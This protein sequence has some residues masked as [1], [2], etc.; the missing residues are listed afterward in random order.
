MKKSLKA[1]L[2]I[3]VVT[4]V[5]CLS[6]SICSAQAFNFETVDPLGGR[7]AV[8]G[9]APSGKYVSLTVL[10]PQKDVSGFENYTE[11]D[12]QYFGGMVAGSSSS[13][14]HGTFEHAED[15]N[16][17]FSFNIN[18]GGGDYT[19]IVN[20][21]GNKSVQTIPVYPAG[22][23]QETIIKIN[24]ATD[25]SAELVDEAIINFSL[26]N[27]PLYTDA[28]SKVT[29][30][31][32]I[33]KL[34]QQNGG[35]FAY[36]TAEDLSNMEVVL[37]DACFIAAY[38]TKNEAVITSDGS[39]LYTNSF[40]ALSGTDEL[41]DYE[42]ISD[43]GLVLKDMFTKTPYTNVG[44]ITKAFKESVRFRVLVDYDAYG[45]G[46]VA[47]Y[48]ERYGDWYEE[49]GFDFNA[50]NKYDY[51]DDVYIAVSASS[52]N[53]INALKKEFNKL[54]RKTSDDSGKSGSS[55]G[56]S[57]G[58]FGS[59]AAPNSSANLP[60]NDDKEGNTTPITPTPVETV[61]GFKDVVKTHW[62]AEAIESLVKDNILNGRGDGTFDVDGTI[63]RAELIKIAVMT[64]V[65][66]ADTAAEAPFEDSKS[67][68]A[69]AYIATAVQNGITTGVTDTSFN[70]DGAITREQAATILYRAFK[71]KGIDFKE[72]NETFADDS[73]ISEWA[74]EAVYALKGIGVISGREN[75]NFC[76]GENLTR[77]EAAKLVHVLRNIK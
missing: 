23:K 65:G 13:C 36:E 35:R 7:V 5:M 64:S 3:A 60:Q 1:L 4:C 67:H 9:T 58:G 53:D 74:K 75:N 25:I 42:K 27:D 73:S 54:V 43:K 40:L 68:W 56:V 16:Y 55:G 17:C 57:Y 49:V 20:V 77:A 12:I 33:K 24:N 46:H 10:K 71:E 69:K 6:I 38:N 70:P 47:G 37:K 51:K 15:G 76:A 28:T 52:A 39:L 45:S 61:G 32:A 59:G 2:T 29:I 22:A 34:K 19:F 8:S 72:T 44:E 26:K 30:G 48:F 41:E 21:N 18:S 50:F 62:A 31:N 14:S 66:N 63:T 11:D